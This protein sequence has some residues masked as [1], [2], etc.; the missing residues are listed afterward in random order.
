MHIV[1]SID[2]D[3]TVS[4][5]RLKIADNGLKFTVKS[6]DQE[7]QRLLSTRG[8]KGS[9]ITVQH[10]NNNIVTGYTVNIPDV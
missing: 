10:D 6:T 3:E 9:T 8:F 5:F 1:L 2:N 7:L 4:S